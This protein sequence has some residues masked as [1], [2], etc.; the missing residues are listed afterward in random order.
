MINKDALKIKKVIEYIK[1]NII[2]FNEVDMVDIKVILDM[3]EDK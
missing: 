3:L 2:P 1:E